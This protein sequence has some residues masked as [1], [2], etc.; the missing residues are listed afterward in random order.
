M[1]DT[2]SVDGSL[3]EWGN[4]LTKL[5]DDP[6]SMGA[7]S[8]DSLLYVAVLIRD[9]DLVQ[10]IAKRGLVVWVDPT[11]GT[12]RTYGVQYPL[13][14]RRQRAGRTGRRAAPS[15]IGAVSLKELE[16][17]RGDTLR[18]RIPARFSSGLRGNVTLDSGVLIGE[19][20]LPVG[21][22]ASSEHGLSTALGPTVGIGLHTPT[23]ENDASHDVSTPE[24]SE[25]DVASSSGPPDRTSPTP[26]R[27][28]R[29]AP[30]PPQP[31]KPTT[32]DRWVTIG[33]P[34]R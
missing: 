32:L 20:A 1:R 10:T 26:Q 4:R 25:P 22:D 2:P 21:P 15:D 6:V 8:T 5:D 31:R 18:T 24:V 29:Q 3:S 28:E 30:K 14:L 13:G 9:A 23:A 34:V 19:L 27:R 33:T 7:V 17:L 11:G 12:N 16:V